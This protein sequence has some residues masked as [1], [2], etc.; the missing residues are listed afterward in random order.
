VDV[1]L[2]LR[3]LD[4][5]ELALD[6]LPIHLPMSAQ[7]LVAFV[8]LEQH[9]VARS[10]VAGSLWPS[11]SERRAG[12]SLRSALWRLRSCDQGIV[13]TAG[14]RLR[15]C[16]GVCVD[17]HEAAELA[18]RVVAG[19][20]AEVAPVDPSAL[21]GEL[22]PD[23]YED[24]VLLER[25]HFRHLRLRALE[26]LCD[27][28]VEAGRLDE[29]LAIGLSALK[30]EPLRESAHRALV[31]VHAAQGNAY[32]AIRQYRLCCRMLRSHGVEPSEQ[33]EALIRTLGQPNALLAVGDGS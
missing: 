17:L 29:A 32:E 15:L 27:R 11:S 16:D 4:V 7:R 14:P 12:A 23:W 21:D 26:T 28:Y 22:L 18:R 3:L 2:R 6:G 1:R 20:D 31:R 19:D 24:W 8:A 25:E 10:L 33:M 5:F 30:S 13:E 9:P